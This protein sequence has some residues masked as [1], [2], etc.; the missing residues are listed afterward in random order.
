[1]RIF[2]FLA[3]ALLVA[4]CSTTDRRYSYV[5]PP[6]ASYSPP[7]ADVRA[8]QEQLRAAGMYDGPIDGVWGPETRAALE[9][10][11]QNRNLPVT[12]RIDDQTSTA[13]RRTYSSRPVALRDPT[14]VR[15]IQNRLRQLNYYQGPDDGVWGS[16]TQM[17]VESFQHSRGL[18]VG[19]MTEAT[20]AAMGLDPGAFSR[21]TA[22]AGDRYYNDRY[23]DQRYSGYSG[24]DPA[25]VREVQRRLRGAGFY[26]GPVDGV[27]G[28]RTQIGLERFQRS[29]G[30]EASGSLNPMTAQALGLNPNNPSLSAAPPRRY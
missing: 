2:A 1:M 26:A 11:Q 3:L 4:A 17:A 20:I 10:Y 9:R 22:Y 12:G 27:W 25:G 14:D 13:L 5:P 7:A 6:T 16:R 24:R 18:P 19:R 21:N 28:S 8:A 15:T 29:R 23:Y 30:L